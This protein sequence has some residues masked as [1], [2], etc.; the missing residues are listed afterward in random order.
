MPFYVWSARAILF[1]PYPLPRTGQRAFPD[2]P[3]GD[4]ARSNVTSA[5]GVCACTCVCGGWVG[6]GCARALVI[7]ALKRAD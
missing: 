1:H 4:A 3:P 6:E 5:Y 7:V 2:S